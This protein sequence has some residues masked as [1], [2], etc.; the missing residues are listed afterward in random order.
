M[1]LLV[2]LSSK[3]NADVLPLACGKLKA[4]LNICHTNV[5][6]NINVITKGCRK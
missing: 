4:G 3:I 1:T 5:I 2:P 6:L